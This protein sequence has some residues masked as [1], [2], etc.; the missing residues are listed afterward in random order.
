M[1]VAGVTAKVTV[2]DFSEIETL[3]NFTV[4]NGSSSYI[5]WDAGE[6]AVF[7]KS[8]RS[9]D[10]HGFYTD[11]G[12][13]Y[14]NS[15]NKSFAIIAHVKVSG[16]SGSHM[17]DNGIGCSDT[18]EWVDS[19]D[20]DNGVASRRYHTGTDYN[21]GAAIMDGSS[22]TF[23]YKTPLW[24]VG[25]IYEYVLN[26][27]C[28][29]GTCVV[30]ATRTG[31]GTKSTVTDTIAVGSLQYCGYLNQNEGGGADYQEGYIYNITVID[32]EP[33]EEPP[34]PEPDQG[35]GNFTVY[36]KDSYTNE[37]IVSFYTSLYDPNGL[38]NETA[39]NGNVTFTDILRGTLWLNISKSL[40]ETVSYSFDL[41]EPSNYSTTA[42]SYFKFN[43]DSRFGENETYGY[44]YTGNGHNATHNGTIDSGYYGDGTFAYD[45]DD[46]HF[47]DLDG[48]IYNSE[49]GTIMLWFKLNELGS[50]Q[51]LVTAG[52]PQTF[53]IR[54][55][56]DNN[57]RLFVTTSGNTC[58]ADT[59]DNNIQADEWYLLTTTWDSVDCKI[60]INGELNETD[61][62][63]GTI[64]T[65]SSIRLGR[66][67]TGSTYPLNGSIDEF[68]FFNH[69]LGA[70]QI[71]TYYEENKIE[72]LPV[73]TN[74]TANISRIPRLTVNNSWNGSAIQNFSVIINGETFS[75][76]DGILERNRRLRG[77]HGLTKR[78]KDTL[79][80]M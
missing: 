62:Y 38:R 51:S 6:G 3:S 47:T 19:G 24:D 30:N 48:D 35:I 55:N 59:T 18:G 23:D 39:T 31:H 50:I 60:Y 17:F 56:N 70:D 1:I 28:N 4:T 10:L 8:V 22:Q 76:N 66:S 79:K 57:I 72:N 26:V 68:L 29:S 21:L 63:S 12:E 78:A 37:D 32:E 2:F 25:N 53:V 16:V 20:F 61:G 69:T 42:N 65:I 43:N 27:T 77:G 5:S 41:N 73:L 54:Y 49:N 13:E 46:T 71:S 75:T 45:K 33:E 9:G 44:D 36:V 34:E 64:D 52:N 40:Y 74:F 11:M 80:T 67:T 7:Y 15:N 14:F 58:L